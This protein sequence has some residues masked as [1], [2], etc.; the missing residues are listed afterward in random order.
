MSATDR[1]RRIEPVRPDLD[2]DEIE[3]PK[4]WARSG[5]ATW[6]LLGPALAAVG[7]IGFL[8]LA[9]GVASSPPPFTWWDLGLDFLL[10]GAFLLPWE[11]LAR[12]AAAVF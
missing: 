12:G 6:L 11:F 7:L 9:G 4:G 8:R 10:L 3:D 1:N 5:L 2:G